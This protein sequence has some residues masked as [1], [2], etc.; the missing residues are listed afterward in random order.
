MAAKRELY[1]VLLAVS[2]LVYVNSLGNA[3]I[4]DDIPAII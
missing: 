3:F 1:L 4:S 2:I